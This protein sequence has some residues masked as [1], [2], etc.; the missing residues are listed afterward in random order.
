MIDYDWSPSIN[1][2]IMQKCF[3]SFKYIFMIIVLICSS[4]KLVQSIISKV[5]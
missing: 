5:I 2:L 3:V 4:S 1:Y